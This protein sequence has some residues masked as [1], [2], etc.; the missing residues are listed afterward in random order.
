LKYLKLQVENVISTAEL[1]GVGRAFDN[2][3]SSKEKHLGPPFLETNA[4]FWEKMR[5]MK[6]LPFNAPDPINTTVRDCESPRHTAPLAFR[7]YMLGPVG[8]IRYT[9]ANTAVAL[10]GCFYSKKHKFCFL[11]RTRKL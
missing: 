6:D 2:F 10:C 9:L 5:V 7:L 11:M 3:R 1:Y 8:N 4:F